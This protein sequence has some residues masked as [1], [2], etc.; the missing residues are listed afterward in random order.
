MNQPQS[1]KHKQTFTRCGIFGEVLVA[2]ET[3]YPKFESD[4]SVR[5]EI[6]KLPSLPDKSTTSR[7]KELL[8]KT[9]Y[10][11][12]RLTPGSYGADDLL[13]WLVK[14]IPKTPLAECR[15]T[16]ER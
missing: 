13:L 8:G 7:V 2:L 6:A 1:P 3:I 9:D 11:V 4:L 15:S 10:H 5:E 16:E 12:G 14:K